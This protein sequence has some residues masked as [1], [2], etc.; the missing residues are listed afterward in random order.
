MASEPS[1]T[2]EPFEATD[3]NGITVRGTVDVYRDRNGPYFDPNSK[4]HKHPRYA[5]AQFD[6]FD[7]REACTI[8]RGVL[9]MAMEDAFA[10]ALTRFGIENPG[11]VKIAEDVD[12]S[13]NATR[14]QCIQNADKYVSNE[15]FSSSNW[16]TGETVG[17]LTAKAYAEVPAPNGGIQT[18]VARENSW[19]SADVAALKNYGSANAPILS[20]R[21][22]TRDGGNNIENCGSSSEGV[23]PQNQTQQAP[24]PASHWTCGNLRQHQADAI[25]EPEGW[26]HAASIR[27]RHRRPAAQFVLPDQLNSFGGPTDWAAAL[28]SLGPLNPMQAVPLPQAGGTPG[29]SSTRPVRYLSRTIA[30]QPQT[31]VFDTS[32][33]TVPFVPFKEVFS[34]ARGN[35]FASGSDASS[36]AGGAGGSSMPGPQGSSASTLLEYIRHLNQLDATKPQPSTVEL[37]DASLAPSDSPIP[38]G[39]LAGRIAAL[40][41]FDP[42]NPDAPPPGGLLKLLLAA[43]QR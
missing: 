8:D 34:P 13:I 23:A 17:D 14:Q 29:I 2:S 41:G 9:S 31:S 37:R 36:P 18:V 32:A 20:R 21:V 22:I 28:A 3:D 40:T 6:Y 26:Q 39:G 7:T 25:S 4:Y 43:Q 38:M 16:E 5:D 30:D 35:A 19:P 10:K 24:P 12:A 27:V 42:D 11:P 15:T 33:P 1:P